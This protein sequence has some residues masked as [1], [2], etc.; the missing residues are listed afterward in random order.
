MRFSKGLRKP[1]E[2]SVSLKVV[3]SDEERFSSLFLIIDLPT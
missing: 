3:V 2:D 1:R